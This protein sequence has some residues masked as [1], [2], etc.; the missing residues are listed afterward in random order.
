MINKANWPYS[1]IYW[2][3]ILIIGVNKQQMHS[4]S[5]ASPGSI[6]VTTLWLEIL[7]VITLHLTKVR[8]EQGKQVFQNHSSSKY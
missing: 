1:D 7:I 6:L 2:I 5:Y 4:T 8:L 3:L